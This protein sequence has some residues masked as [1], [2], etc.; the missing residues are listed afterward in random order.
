MERKWEVIKTTNSHPTEVANA[1]LSLFAALPHSEMRKLL[2]TTKKYHP[3][4]ATE[5]LSTF[6]TLK[7]YDTK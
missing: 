6:E 3:Q 4:I 2:T 1:F 5:M 7:K